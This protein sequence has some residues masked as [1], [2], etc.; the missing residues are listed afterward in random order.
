VEALVRVYLGQWSLAEAVR[1][2]QVRTEGSRELGRGMAEW[3]PRSGFA[4]HAQPVSFDRATES[5]VLASA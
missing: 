2:G 1:C 5:F 4:P 3:F